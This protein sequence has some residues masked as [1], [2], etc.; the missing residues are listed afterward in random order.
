MKFAAGYELTFTN[1]ELIEAGAARGELEDDTLANLAAC[2][3]FARELHES[4]GEHEHVVEDDGH[5]FP[6]HRFRFPD[7]YWIKLEIDPWVVEVTGQHLTID[8][9]REIAP[10]LEQVFTSA[11]RVDLFPHERIGGGHI[12]IDRNSFGSELAIRNF[13]VDYF[14]HPELALGVLGFDPL[15]AAPLATAPMTSVE[16][17]RW[18]LSRFDANQLDLAG[19]LEHLRTKVYTYASPLLP[20]RARR[21]K[22]QAV[23]VDHPST[24]EIRALRPQR[25]F[26]EFLGLLDLFASRIDALDGQGPIPYRH[27]SWPAGVPMVS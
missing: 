12:H 13:L 27:R 18:A 19:F 21:S 22:F 23:S 6:C 26:A 4:V 9:Y 10:R 25:S 20:A 2:D 14:N 1:P 11:A 8:G 7:G 5:G 24:I 3:A 15:N 17:L 16:E